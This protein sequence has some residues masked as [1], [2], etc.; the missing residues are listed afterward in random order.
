MGPIYRFQLPGSRQRGVTTVFRHYNEC[1][2]AWLLQ[3]Q[4]EGYGGGKSKDTGSYRMYFDGATLYSYGVHYPLARIFHVN[5]VL[6]ILVNTTK[7]TPTTEGQKR[8]VRGMIHQMHGDHAVFEVP[9]K[10]IKSLG[11]L[12]LDNMLGVRQ[13]IY[14]EY[15]TVVKIALDDASRCRAEHTKRAHL[16]LASQYVLMGNRLAALFGDL[17]L[18]PTNAEEAEAVRL[19][20]LDR[21]LM[22]MAA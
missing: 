6:Y 18:F 11:G 14:A 2:R 1:I 3:T 13:E 21:G 19:A 20:T 8:D 4:K 16:H 12:T 7:S 17:V 22:Q 9:G 10:I 15:E 5:E